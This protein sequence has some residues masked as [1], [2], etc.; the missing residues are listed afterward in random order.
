MIELFIIYLSQ[1][2]DRV[3]KD[4]PTFDSV[5]FLMVKNNYKPITIWKVVM[6]PRKLFTVM[7]KMEVQNG[8]QCEQWNDQVWKW[9]TLI[10]FTE[11]NWIKYSDCQILYVSALHLSAFF[12]PI[13]CLRCL[14]FGPF[15]PCVNP[16]QCRCTF[17]CASICG[18]KAGGC[19]C[20]TS[21][22]IYNNGPW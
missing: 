17:W 9:K 14:M 16:F 12:Y 20:H 11:I 1:H 22:C 15:S 7:R 21:N 5:F 10:W 3:Q 2:D 8:C 19:K 6:T 13:I 4:A 18:K